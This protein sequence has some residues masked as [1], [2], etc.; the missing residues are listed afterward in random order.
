MKVFAVYGYKG[1]EQLFQ[2]ESDAVAFVAKCESDAKAHWF[3]TFGDY[4][5]DFDHWY[6]ETLE[7]I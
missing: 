1:L 3:D 7:V 6:I 2:V 4:D 5:G